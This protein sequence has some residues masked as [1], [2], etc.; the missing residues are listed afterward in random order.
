MS[1]FSNGKYARFISD[2]S[3][4]EFPYSER[5]EE[6]TGAIVHVSEYEAKQPQLEPV[7][8]PFEP[9]ALYQPRPDVLQEM[10][11]IIAESIFGNNGITIAGYHGMAIT[12]EVEIITP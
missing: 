6:W 12:G 2:R 3:G 8:A 5:I 4:M 9:Q 7:K 1:K 10:V 11:I